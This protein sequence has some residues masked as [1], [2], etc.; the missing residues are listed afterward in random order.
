MMEVII[1][2]L[3]NA[4]F[5]LLN[6]D[7]NIKNWKNLIEDYDK[8]LGMLNNISIYFDFSIISYFFLK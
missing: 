3:P 8:R 6:L 7:N 4:D 2:F 5:L 1:N